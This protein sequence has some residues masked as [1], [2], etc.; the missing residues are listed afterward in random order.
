MRRT[1]AM[2]IASAPATRD[3]I[4][5]DNRFCQFM[6]TILADGW[7]EDKA[8]HAVARDGALGGI[9]TAGERR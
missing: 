6:A 4:C 3:N 9:G 1:M 7:G 2:M 5:N 8:R